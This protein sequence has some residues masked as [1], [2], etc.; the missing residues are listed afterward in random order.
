MAPGLVSIIYTFM[1]QIIPSARKLS[2]IF[3]PAIKVAVEGNM[4]VIDQA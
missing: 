1:N 4:W 2:L 3:P